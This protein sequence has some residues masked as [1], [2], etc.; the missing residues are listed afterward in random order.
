MSELFRKKSVEH[1]TQRLRGNV[2]LAVPLSTSML[3]GLVLLILVIAIAFV[4]TASYARKETVSGWLTPQSGMVRATALRGGVVESVFVEEGQNV[5]EGAPLVQVRLATHISGGN[6]GRV[7]LDSLNRQADA[8][9]RVA[10]TRIERLNG[11]QARLTGLIEALSDEAIQLSIQISLQQERVRLAEAE[12]ERAETI[13]S[14]GFMSARDV[15]AR[16]NALLLVREEAA[17]LQRSSASLRRQ[18]RDSRF[19][20]S[21]IPVQIAAAE[22]ESDSALAILSERTTSVEAQSSYQVTSPTDARVAALPIMR[23]QTLNAGAAVAILVP[24]GEDLTAELYIPSRASGFIREGQ[25]VRLLYQA[26]PHQRFGVGFGEIVQISSTV[27]APSEVSLPGTPVAE[28]VFRVKAVLSR[29][30][31]EAYGETVPLQPGMLLSAEI[32][33]D[34]RTLLEWLFDPLFAAGRR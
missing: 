23:G 9:A 32:I 2:V 10:D 22:A 15:Q 11:E 7:L 14:R 8:A 20:L 13:S 16:Q 4:S 28:P 27:L 21:M 30:S 25:E 19:Q 17:S 18:L 26:F 3:A 34:R 33:I 1:A 31:V 12:V 29:Q 6:S 24:E 5:I